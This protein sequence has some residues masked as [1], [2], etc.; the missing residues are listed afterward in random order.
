M[1]ILFKPSSAIVR[2][3]LKAHSSFGLFIAAVLYL[4]CITGVVSVYYLDL[5]RWEQAQ[6]P[7]FTE[8]TPAQIHN[9]V[10]SLLAYRS[11][12][13]PDAK[14]FDDVWVSLPTRDMPRF[15]VG[16][17]AGDEELQFFVNRDGSFGEKVNHEWT[18]F[19]TRLHLALTL[20]GIWGLAIVGIVGMILVSLV[21]SGL[22]AHP[23]MF[24]NAFSLRVNRGQRQQQVDI[25]NRIGVWASPFILIIAV[26]GALIGLAQIFLWIFSANFFQNDTRVI[27]NDL[28]M[29]HP[30][31]T[32]IAA[33]LLD[34][35]NI[36]ETFA[37]KYPQLQPTYFTI[38]FPE[39]TAQVLELGAYLPDRLVWYDAF[40]FN[41]RGELT[42][43]LG[44]PDG[45]LGMQ[46]YASVF[47]LHFG[48]FG[49]LPVKILYTLLGLG[50]CFM[51]ATGMNIWFRRQQQAGKPQDQL[52]IAWLGVVWGLP[53]AIVFT[54][55][56]DFWWQDYSVVIFWLI[57]LLLIATA[58]VIKNRRAVS[59]GL[60]LLLALLIALLIVIHMIFF[61]VSSWTGASILINCLWLL[62]FILIATPLFLQYITGRKAIIQEAA[63]A[64]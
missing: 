58:P 2:A 14:P 18:H 55:I 46:I 23:N 34:T 10:K 33:P 49:G 21:I 36:L 47:R 45:D 25:H 31:P 20:P 1:T 17:R 32:E 64:P 56:I 39:T 35:K 5:E 30:Q 41:A 50:M 63:L 11:Q 3:N 12:N 37:Q 4:I 27:S 9:A 28:F 40:Q 15:S 48:H 19:I 53:C 6:V 44:W 54:A 42:K 60:R 62:S 13:S 16:G 61:G 43:R 52:E 26:T 8:V 22:L 38:H 57:S 24:K 7:E 59:R 29:P 51:C